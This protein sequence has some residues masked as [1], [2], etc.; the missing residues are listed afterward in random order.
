MK[1][2]DDRTNRDQW[3]KALELGQVFDYLDT[4]YMK[5]GIT[6]NEPNCVNLSNGSVDTFRLTTKVEPLD[7]RLTVDYEGERSF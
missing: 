1:I 3:F 6:E 4:I 7:A 2:I 5:T